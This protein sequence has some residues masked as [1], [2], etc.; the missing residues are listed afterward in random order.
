MIEYY[1][2]LTVTLKYIDVCRKVIRSGLLFETVS[3]NA[4]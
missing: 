4:L 3:K 1:N 2:Q